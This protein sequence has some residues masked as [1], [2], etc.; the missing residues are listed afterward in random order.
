MRE[1]KENE[2][3]GLEETNEKSDEAIEEDNEVDVQFQKGKELQD[4]LVTSQEILVESNCAEV[5][6]SNSGK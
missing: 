1:S 4:N 2:R 6:K 3:Q 5:I